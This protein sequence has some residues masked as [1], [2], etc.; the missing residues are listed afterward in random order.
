MQFAWTAF[1]LDNL[2]GCFYS[3]TQLM[4]LVRAPM[5]KS[6]TA[7]PQ[8]TRARQARPKKAR[9]KNASRQRWWLAFAKPIG[10]KSLA[11][12]IAGLMVISL[13]PTLFLSYLGY[14]EHKALAWITVTL[15]FGTAITLV[16]MYLIFGNL[17]LPSRIEDFLKRL[18]RNR[19]IK[20]DVVAENY[21]SKVRQQSAPPIA[22]LYI[23]AGYLFVRSETAGAYFALSVAT[24]L[25]VHVLITRFRIA[26][27]IFGSNSQE[28]SELIAYI[29]NASKVDGSPPGSRIGNPRRAEE[30]RDVSSAAT[31]SG[32]A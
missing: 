27:G 12:S 17:I 18:R 30:K 31:A 9:P 25:L 16:S 23:L 6:K 28:A 4:V 7:K 24:V 8:K 32:V 2:L 1:A 22:L 13:P 5:A 15:T 3:Y 20:R 14:S 29:I 11:T 21:F 26:R 10:P 19:S